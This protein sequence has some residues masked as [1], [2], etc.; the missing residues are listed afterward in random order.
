M[1]SLLICQ[2]FVSAPEYKP[3]AAFLVF[4]PT[5]QRL[6]VCAMHYHEMQSILGCKAPG[7]PLFSI[8]P[9]T[10]GFSSTFKSSEQLKR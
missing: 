10:K 2:F 1:S 8:Q 3:P 5:L 4:F 7:Q 9:N 6:D